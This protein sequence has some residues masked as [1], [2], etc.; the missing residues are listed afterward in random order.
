MKSTIKLVILVL[1]GYCAF[2]YAQSRG[3]VQPKTSQVQKRWTAEYTMIKTRR[4]A[5]PSR[6]LDRDGNFKADLLDLADT[7]EVARSF[8]GYHNKFVSTR[9][10]LSSRLEA[11]PEGALKREVRSVL[12]CYSDADR[13]WGYMAKYRIDYLSMDLELTKN[14]I[15]K[16]RIETDGSALSREVLLRAVF[17]RAANSIDRI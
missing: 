16:Y 13:A 5:K 10:R 11:L 1:L 3:K 4:E 6:R 15:K 2:S 9:K 17:A 7:A 12:E 8:K 14:L